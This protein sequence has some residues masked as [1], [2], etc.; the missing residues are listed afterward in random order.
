MYN[1]G[2][3]A[4]KQAVQTSGISMLEDRLQAA[5]ARANQINEMLLQ[6]EGRM[7]TPRPQ[8]SGLDTVSPSTIANSIENSINMLNTELIGIEKIAAR[9]LQG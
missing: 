9:I 6:I 1:A 3:E 2:Q 7:Y 4:N 8:P 5:H